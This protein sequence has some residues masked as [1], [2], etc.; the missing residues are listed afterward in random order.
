MLQFRLTEEPGVDRN[1]FVPHIGDII[2]FN[3]EGCFALKDGD[4][5]VGMVTTTC[6]QTV[7]WIGWLYVAEKYRRQ[8][9]GGRLMHKAIDY[10]R[11][12]GIRTM[13][14]EAVVKAVPLYER[15]G[16]ARQFRTEHY[17]LE[18]QHFTP[19]T[20][21]DILI[22]SV[23]E[24]SIDEIA[25]FDRSFFHQDRKELFGIVIHN[26][27]FEGLIA[28]TNGRIVGL[29]FLTEDSGKRRV[30]PM[31]VDPTLDNWLS[32]M[33]TLVRAA[34]ARS[35]KPLYFRCPLI[36]PDRARPLTDLGAR[37]VGRHSL[38][39]SLGTSYK[40]EKRG[41]VSSGSPGKG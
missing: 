1:W 19:I 8:G 23:S 29:L 15:L 36:Q 11:T 22:H 16:F 9:L 13:V 6:Y 12:R 38:R 5:V 30:S 2:A 41:V 17:Q 31:V 18:Q 24:D 3:P 7:G 37:P 39:M 20:N 21:S 14:L 32:I 4:E 10:I 35:A 25:S 33:S 34:F 27:I 28:R 26:R 40:P